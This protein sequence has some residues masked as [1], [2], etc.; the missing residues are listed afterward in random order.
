MTIERKI[1]LFGLIPVNNELVA[2]GALVECPD[3]SDDFYVNRLEVLSP[4]EVEVTHSPTQKLYEFNRSIGL[5]GDPNEGDWTYQQAG[6]QKTYKA[7]EINRARLWHPTKFGLTV[8]YVWK[9]TPEE[10]NPIAT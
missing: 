9:S 8:H 6:H 2:T 1:K 3:P 7:S 10:T 5:G 4:D